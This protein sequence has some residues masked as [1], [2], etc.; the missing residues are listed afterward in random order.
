MFPGFCLAANSC[1]AQALLV[2]SSFWNNSNRSCMLLLP[3]RFPNLTN[4]SGAWKQ[5]IIIVQDGLLRCVSTLPNHLRCQKNV[6]RIYKGQDFLSTLKLLT[7]PRR[8]SFRPSAYILMW[9]LICEEFGFMKNKINLQHVFEK[10]FVC[11]EIDLSKQVFRA[12]PRRTRALRMAVR[13][14]NLNKLLGYTK[15]IRNDKPYPISSSSN[16]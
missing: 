15:L 13:F 9:L 8:F 6:Y 2:V 1:C 4:G 10:E 11:E 3:E 16:E 14:S 7:E 12:Y 5:T